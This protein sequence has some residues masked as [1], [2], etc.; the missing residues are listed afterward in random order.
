MPLSHARAT[1][2]CKASQIW[3]FASMVWTCRFTCCRFFQ[4]GRRA[5]K[6]RKG[7]RARPEKQ[8]QLARFH[9]LPALA[10][11]FLHRPL[12]TPDPSESDQ[13]IQRIRVKPHPRSPLMV[14]WCECGFWVNHTPGLRLWSDNRNARFV[15]HSSPLYVAHLMLRFLLEQRVASCALQRLLKLFFKPPAILLL[16]YL[17]WMQKML[18]RTKCHSPCMPARPS[19]L[20]LGRSRFDLGL[21]ARKMKASAGKGKDRDDLQIIDRSGGWTSMEMRGA[22]EHV[23]DKRGEKYKCLQYTASKRL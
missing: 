11:C 14:R 23:K 9:A 21:A 13:P 10:T 3:K 2:R 4:L 18:M 7:T 19:A 5:C 6:C 17:H 12:Q 20:A 1:P 15:F 22:T 16:V 8:Q